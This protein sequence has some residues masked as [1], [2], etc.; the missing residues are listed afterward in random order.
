M[1]HVASQEDMEMRIAELTPFYRSTVGFDR[2]LDLLDQVSRPAEPDDNFPPLDIERIG[3]DRY[4]ITMALAGYA[5]DDLVIMAEPN[6]LLVEGLKPDNESER[7]FLH[8][9][10]AR[11]PFRRQ[12]ELADFVRAVG[13]SYE[14][15]LL[16]IELQRELPEAMK[17]KRIEISTGAPPRRAE[18]E[19]RGERRAETS[20]AA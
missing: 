17:P 2:M 1:T 19:R 16:S 12:F 11:R 7:N 10:I 3:E 15:G 5:P 9:G 13:A 14:N 6:V 18:S 8:R 4:R 20:S